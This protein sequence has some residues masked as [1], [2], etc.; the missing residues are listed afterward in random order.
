M[1]MG[2]SYAN[3]VVFF[4]AVVLGRSWHRIWAPHAGVAAFATLLLAA[5]VLHWDRF[6]HAH[7]VFWVWITLYATAPVLVPIALAR[8]A[9]EDPGVPEP[10]DPLVPIALRRA[11][12]VPGLA[13]L[14]VA[15]AAFVAPAWLIPFWPWKATPLTMRVIV[16]FYSMLGVAVLTVQNEPRWSAWRIGALGV[17]TWHA[18]ILIAALALREDLV[19]GTARTVWLACEAG[20]LLGSLGTL[21]F[22]EW[23]RQRGIALA[24]RAT[25]R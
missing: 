18:L 13:F 25:A 7:P 8:N 6:N 17:V 10:G 24:A 5:T 2:A 22:M 12:L 9:R 4:A 3:G 21:V 14:A 20:L 16:S 1:F 15:L 11:W 19:P 23:R